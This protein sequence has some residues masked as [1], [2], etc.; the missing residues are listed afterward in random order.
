MRKRRGRAST[1]VAPRRRELTTTRRDRHLAAV[2]RGHRSRDVRRHGNRRRHRRARDV[3]AQEPFRPAA[4]RQRGRKACATQHG[5]RPLLPAARG[6]GG[7][8]ERTG[9]GRGDGH[10]RDRPGAAR[11]PVLRRRRQARP[12]PVAL[13]QATATTNS[14]GIA[15]SPSFRAN[16]TAGTFTATAS[17]TGVS[18]SLSF[19][20]RNRP[21]SA[22]D[23]QRRRGRNRVDPGR[24]AVP[25]PARRHRH[26][27]VRE[28]RRR[29][30]GPLRRTRVAAR[31][32]RFVHRHRR[33]RTV[34]VE[35][36]RSTGSPSH[37]RCNANATAGGY[38]VTATAGQREAGGVRARQPTAPVSVGIES[39]RLHVVRPGA[40]RE[41]RSADPP[42]PR[43]ALGARNRDRCRSDRRGARPLVVVAGRSARRDRHA[44]NEPAHRQQRPDAVRPD[45]RAAARRAGD[46]LPASGRCS[47]SQDTGST[48]RKRLPQPAHPVGEYERTQRSGGEP[49][50][51][52]DRRHDRRT[53]E[54][55]QRRDRAPSR[56]RCSAPQQ[57]SGSASTASTR[58][59]GSGSAACGSTSPE[60]STRPRSPRRSTDPSSSGS[61]PRS[62]TSASTGIRR[63]FTCAA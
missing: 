32:G 62:A 54:L 41:R 55:P 38:V 35:D 50:A 22:C 47:R 10:L 4:A 51:A 53:R 52:R 61:P 60:S 39:P 49:R 30:A 18:R 21:G 36:E 5:R 42:D 31:A 14:A 40:R 19:T 28:R 56:S 29:R 11:R 3:R 13:T 46:D 27:Q 26:R 37:L 7:R 44:R 63:L 1:A 17:A 24:R 34:S 48:A 45:R 2:R 15:S 25:D 58:A 59:S 57:R 8:R 33:A 16:S 43:G 6:Q 23:D 12:S 20:L 9:R